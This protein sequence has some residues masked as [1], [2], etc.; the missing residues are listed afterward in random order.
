MHLQLNRDKLKRL[1]HHGTL[2]VLVMGVGH[3]CLKTL[4]VWA[5]QGKMTCE[6]VV[7]QE[8]SPRVAPQRV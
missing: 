1:R 4:P 3:N 8:V 6:S 7:R 2:R 5:Y